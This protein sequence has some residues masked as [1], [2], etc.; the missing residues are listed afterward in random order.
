MKSMIRLP[1]TSRMV[2]AAGVLGT[3]SLS[4]AFAAQAI[5]D[6]EARAQ[7]SWREAMART[8]VPAEGC[9]HSSYPS[10]TWNKVDCIVAPDVPYVPRS[11]RVRETVGNGHDYAAQVTSGLITRSVGS[12]PKVTGVTSESGALGANDYSLQLNSN[13]MNTPACDGALVPANCLDWEQFVY[14]S[15]FGEAFMQYWLI[16]WDTTCPSGWI[17][18]GVGDCYKNSAAAFVPQE[19]I[20]SLKTLKLSGSAKAGGKDTLVFTVGT[21]AFSTTGKDSVVDLATAWVESEFNIIGD[22]NGSAARFNTG[23]SV[24]VKVAVA[25]GTTNTP[26]CASNAGTTG[27]TNNLNLGSCTGTSATTPYIKFVESN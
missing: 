12:F 26:V 14:A 4:S 21:Q 8:E 11:G 7:E 22:G 18:D 25:N 10:M 20:T 6:A 15:G 24:T 27:E 5:D 17:S 3:A 13:F 9:F 1:R 23:S 2:I 16:S 19:P